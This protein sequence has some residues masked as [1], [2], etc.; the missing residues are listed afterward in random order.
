MR[1][2]VAVAGGVLA[3]VAIIPYIADIIKGKT[4]PNIVSWL[5][6]TLLLA[7]GT[8]GAFAAH[9]PR[10]AF[11]T[12]GDLVG[13]GITLILGLKFDGLCQLGAVAGLILWFTLSSPAVGI[14]AVVIV[15]LIGLLP[16]LKHSWDNPEEETW[17]TFG[18]LTLASG[19]TLASLTRFNV[20]SLSYPIYL[21]AAN[22][23]VTIAVIYRRLKL[24]IK[25]SVV[26]IHE[27]MHE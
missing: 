24:G 25:L 2:T 13:T 3:A 20:S 22:T 17:Q 6:W 14:I 5:T 23:S 7:I 27:T 4:K 12:M 11:L 18:V 9:D 1:N 10:T 26:G 15:D 19:L 8:A 21:L 16:T